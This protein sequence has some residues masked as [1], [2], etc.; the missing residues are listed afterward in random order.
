MTY[1]RM[2]TVARG[3]KAELLLPL[4]LVALGVAI[5]L[6][7]IAAA[8]L[9]DHD[10]VISVIAATCNQIRYSETIPTGQWV[11][12]AEWQQYW[13]L[14]T[15]GCF[16][17]IQHG[18]TYYDIHPPLYFWLLHIWFSVFGVSILSGLVLNLVILLITAVIIYASCR[19]LDVSKTF[20]FIVSAA[21]MLSLYSRMT[22][23]V[24]RQYGL[25]SM[26][27]ALL[28]LLTVLWLKKRQPGYVFGIAIVLVAGVLTHYQ[29]VIPA[30]ITFLCACAILARRR[31]YKEVTQ[32]VVAA[33]LAALTFYLSHPNF[34]VSVGRAD[35][36]AQSFSLVGFVQRLGSVVGT[37]LQLFNPL[38][39]SHPLPFGLLD[40]SDPLYAAINLLNVAVGGAGLYFAARLAI[41]AYRKRPSTLDAMVA[42]DFLPFVAGVASWLA[43]IALYIFFVSPVHAIGLQYLHFVTPFLFVGLGQAAEACKYSIPRKVVVAIPP[44]LIVGAALATALFVGHRSELL[45]IDEI[46][47]ADALILD[48]DKIGIL[49]TVVWH[50]NP[51]TKVY[52]AAT[53]DELLA[54]LPDPATVAGENLFYAS[55]LAYG[56]TPEKRQ[57]ILGRL[58]E[59]GYRNEGG[60]SV[61]V[62][63][64]VPLGGEIYAFKH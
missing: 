61:S 33:G 46:K 13:Q 10:D 2:L 60:L 16:D 32:L 51:A 29:F 8:V 48:S 6:P 37:V 20:S 42:V 53:Q 43:I 35:A 47:Q 38:D 49:P 1:R 34:L 31:Q 27:A 54:N 22:I 36:Q 28:L 39:W 50:A 59:M 12:A 7:R 15:F 40:F 55:S 11:S 9:I 30:L 63:Y 21:W 45:R 14:N 5:Y 26:L 3:F 24:I 41:R 44:L 64:L 17:Q 62:V 18:L 19:V 57:Q 52:A 4:L 56:N 25:F 58:E 23:G